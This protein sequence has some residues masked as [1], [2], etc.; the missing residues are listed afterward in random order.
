M[1]KSRASTISRNERNSKPAKD[2]KK[3]PNVDATK[4]SYPCNLPAN[5]PQV[6]KQTSVRGDLSH[7][8]TK[9]NQSTPQA[10]LSSIGSVDLPSYCTAIGSTVVL[11]MHD[12]KMA[13]TKRLS[14][15][16]TLNLVIF[17]VCY[18][19][20]RLQLKH[21]YLYRTLSVSKIN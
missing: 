3:H 6:V 15:W 19:N 9:Q 16:F 7:I 13:R 2:T 4:Q 21:R 5:P 11:M 1:N 20:Y 10:T 12:Q 14:I 18:L 8:Q 17:V